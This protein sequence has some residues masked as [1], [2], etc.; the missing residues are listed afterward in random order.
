[1]ESGLSNAE[2]T[3]RLLPDNTIPQR[4]RTGTTRCPYRGTFVRTG[5]SRGPINRPHRI[6]KTQNKRFLGSW[7][8]RSGGTGI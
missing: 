2:Q 8:R 3:C 4:T 7:E 5:T 1:M 6:L